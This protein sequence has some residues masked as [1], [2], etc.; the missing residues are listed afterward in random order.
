M[1]L[2]CVS[3]GYMYIKIVYFFVDAYFY[4]GTSGSRPSRSGTIV[5]NEKGSLKELKRYPKNSNIVINV[6]AGKT[7]H[8]MAWLSVWCEDFSVSFFF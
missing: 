5:P 7:V 4:F 8:D 1:H 3:L 6:P 2:H